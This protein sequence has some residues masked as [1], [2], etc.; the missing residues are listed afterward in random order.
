MD[1]RTKRDHQLELRLLVHQ[2]HRRR[3]YRPH[4]PLRRQAQKFTSRWIQ[5]E[6]ISEANAIQR[7]ILMIAILP[8]G[9]DKTA[10]PKWLC[11]LLFNFL[12]R[13]SA[14]TLVL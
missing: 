1:H 12:T 7:P 2:I 11:L 10:T 5:L 13:K 8:T 3:L 4:L 6:M 9:Q 14:G